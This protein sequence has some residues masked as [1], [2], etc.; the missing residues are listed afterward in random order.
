[1]TVVSST[2]LEKFGVVKAL[3]EQKMLLENNQHVD[4]VSL[5]IHSG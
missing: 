3:D 4:S 2:I 1:M 5:Q